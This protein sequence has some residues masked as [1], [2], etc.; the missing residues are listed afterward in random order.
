MASSGPLGIS[1]FG[2][3]MYDVCM[4]VYMPCIYTCMYVCHDPGAYLEMAAIKE[5][6]CLQDSL[7]LQSF[8]ST[9]SAG[10]YGQGF[11]LYVVE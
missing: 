1:Q 2:M 10:G 9:A 4:Y 7:S 6:P 11:L 5:Y 3:H 8:K